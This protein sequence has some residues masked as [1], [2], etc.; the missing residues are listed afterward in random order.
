MLPGAAHRQRARALSL[1]GLLVAIGLL[2][3]LIAGP[4]PGREPHTT[5]PGVD[6]VAFYSGA[7]VAAS[8]ADPYR[9]EPLRSVEDGV[10]IR[11]KK[12]PGAVVP[13]P[14]PGY[15]FVIFAPFAAMP[16]TIAS[17]IWFGLLAL[18]VA[19]TIGIVHKLTRA[20]LVLITLTLIASEGL[21]SMILGQVVPITIAAACVAAYALRSGQRTL[22]VCAAALTTMEPHLGLPV[23]LAIFVGDRPSRRPL[24]IAGG[25][26]AAAA[27]WRLGPTVN[28][29]YLTQVLPAHVRTEIVNFPAQYSLTALLA[30]LGVA[31]EFAVRAGEI[32]YAVMLVLGVWAG[33][34]LARRFDDRAFIP[35]TPFATILLGGP[36]LHFHQIAAAIPLAWL[37]YANLPRLRVQLAI[38]LIALAIPWE[39]IAE[40]DSVEQVLGLYRHPG[41]EAAIAAVSGGHRLAEDAWRAFIETGRLTSPALA[42]W[43]IGF[44]LPTWTALGILVATS[45]RAARVRS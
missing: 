31:H 33:R 18:A 22:A 35:L 30:Q 45:A 14:L 26:L 17:R 34:A 15:A 2:A 32:S 28:W 38:A 11:I 24:L 25:T 20:P 8:G 1:A 5:A 10:S 44:K 13:S 21:T 41:A 23:V 19:A 42:A 9:A 6:F 7:R 29:E 43:S 40:S 3:A 4:G 16:F 12:L 27:L 36:F 39:G 37:L